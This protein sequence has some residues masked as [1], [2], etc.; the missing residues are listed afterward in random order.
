MSSPSVLEDIG[1]ATQRP[2][3]ARAARVW[4]DIENP[5]QVQ[6]LVPL[7]T[8]LRRDSHDVVVTARDY[9]ATYQLL[10]DH[11]S[12]FIPV[13]SH[14]GAARIAKVA[15]SLR[16]VR[17]L[18]QLLGG[19]R[20]PDLV[21]SASRSASLTARSFGIPS[22]ALCDY[23]H[24]NLSVFR[25]ARSHIVHPS[26]ISVDSFRARGVRPELLVPYEGIKEAITFAD[27]DLGAIPPH[28]FPELEG[29]RA[30]KVL[31]RPAAEESHYHRSSSSE[32]AKSVL[33]WLAARSD[34]VVIYS[35]RYPWQASALGEFSWRHPPVVLRNAVP[36]VQLYKAVD[37]VISGG[38]TMIREAA[39]LGIPAVSTFQGSP[40]DV[41]R[42]LA[43]T[44]RLTSV[45]DHTDL[46]RLD[47]AALERREPLDSNVRARDDVLDAVLRIASRGHV[48]RTRTT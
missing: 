6:Y 19:S 13:G 2:A 20:R 33:A 23:E 31:V 37:V 15:G 42:Y 32:V 26:V 34:V 29:I 48:R 17:E 21:V 27:V 41:D 9:G 24:V 16:R 36:F 3:A 14:F 35:P 40:G 44:G 43:S 38:G 5:P 18:R 4:V 8:G 39:Y 46:D 45:T 47:L 25:F 28:R 22:F 10:R 11:G 30:L 12:E 1:A 7:V